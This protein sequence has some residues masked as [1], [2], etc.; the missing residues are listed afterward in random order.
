V[1]YALFAFQIGESEDVDGI[2]EPTDRALLGA[3][4]RAEDRAMQLQFAEN[5]AEFCKAW[6]KSKKGRAGAGR[7]R[8]R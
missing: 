5:F 3:L 4:L 1:A 7:G 8:K 6:V 2:R